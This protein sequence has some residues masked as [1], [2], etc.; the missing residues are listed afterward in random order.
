MKTSNIIIIGTFIVFII[1]FAINAAGLKKMY[2][3]T[4]W[5]DPYRNY[6]KH[7]LN[8]TIDRVYVIAPDSIDIWTGDSNFSITQGKSNMLML[9]NE[10][11]ASWQITDSGLVVRLKHNAKGILAIPDIKQVVIDKISCKLTNFGLDSLQVN[12]SKKDSKLVVLNSKINY[13]NASV[14]DQGQL[15]IEKENRINKL[16]L[17]LRGGVFSSGVNI[18]EVSQTIT[19]DS[20]IELWSS[21]LQKVAQEK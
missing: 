4:N 21:A 2:D 13:L 5:N 15:C 19:P 14:S 12:I 18:R 11:F 1:G 9:Q 6:T 17:V 20:R 3:H 7:S 8:K 10:A 16:N